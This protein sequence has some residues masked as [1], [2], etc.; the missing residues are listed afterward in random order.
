MAQHKDANGWDWV[1]LMQAENIEMKQ[2]LQYLLHILDNDLTLEAEF[3]DH[4]RE[5][6]GGKYVGKWNIP[7][8]LDSDE[9]EPGRNDKETSEREDR[10]IGGRVQSSSGDKGESTGDD[11]NPR[12]IDETEGGGKPDV[13]EE[14]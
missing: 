12:E 2:S 1:S 4:I 11:T 7:P 10:D 9:P 6:V 14:S 8:G 13:D 3:E 5:L